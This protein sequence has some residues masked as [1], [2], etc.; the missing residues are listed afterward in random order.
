MD[1]TV[2]QR[3]MGDEDLLNATYS[4]HELVAVMVVE[5]VD[6]IPCLSTRSRYYRRSLLR[7]SIAVFP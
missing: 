7:F 1:V 6:I 3:C 4:R 2:T 5:D